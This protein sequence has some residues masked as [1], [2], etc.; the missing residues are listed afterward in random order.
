M[1]LALAQSLEA[2][3]VKKW[4]ERRSPALKRLYVARQAAEQRRAA[5]AAVWFVGI[6]YVVFV[7]AD[8]VLIPDMIGWAFVAR[9]IVGL[10]YAT[11]ISWQIQ[12]GVRPQF[13]EA[14]CA[15]GVVAGCAAWFALIAASKHVE[16]VLYYATFGPVFMMVAN[17]FFNFRFK[18]AV[19]VSGSIAVIFL[20][21]ASLFFKAG[22]EYFF[23][24]GSLYVLSLFLT[25]FLNWKLEAERYRVFLNSLS[26]DLRHQEARE[27]GEELL[28]IS[29]TDALTGLANRRATDGV[30]QMLWKDWTSHEASFA[31]ALIDIDYFK[32]FNDYYGHQR[33][34][35]CLVRVADA[36]EAVALRHR[37]KL[38]RF[39]GE[40][41]I[42]LLSCPTLPDAQIVSE[43]LRQAVQALDI[44][45][46][47]RRDGTAH[48]TVSVGVAFS[49]DVVGTKAERIV[50]D[51]DR[52]LYLAKNG[53]RNCVRAF[54]P[55]AFEND[56]SEDELHELVRT[57]L[58]GE[59]V[60]LVYQPI[61]DLGTGRMMGAE[62][63][64]RLRTEDGRPVSPTTFI[65]IAERTGLIFEFGEWAIRQAC[66]QLLACEAL[67]L[68]SVNV[69]VMQ[70]VQPGF[71][72]AVSDIL[73]RAGV[74]P[75]RLALEITEGAEIEG[76]PAVVQAVADLT[77]LGAKVWLDDFGTGFAGL[78]CLRE[79]RFDAV[80]VDGSFVRNSGT[81]RGARLLRDIISLVQNANSRLVVEGIESREQ[82]ELLAVLGVEL[83]QGYYF[84][85][86]MASEALRALSVEKKSIATTSIAA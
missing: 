5:H 33:G 30:L 60:S 67:P 28:K 4:R 78:S 6:L 32:T 9:V 21:S 41:F 43:E 52:A 80:K 2:E 86:P 50:T 56:G 31:V 46:E 66:Q 73:A 18:I 42:L 20:M 17:L 82:A 3:L 63:L 44:A 74:S 57:A 12:R 24:V 81:P 61:W 11:S 35:T 59:R 10:A 19:A 84:A 71:A 15:L 70:L 69:S 8:F 64:M 29:K 1:D 38:G 75:S 55:N 23:A 49:R 85:R 45:H 37:A 36:M 51:A 58:A 25:L 7:A 72:T 83:V 27:R 40:E 48:V 68:I 76:R 65:P 62:A 34:D 54:D 77:S 79:L 53:G 26:A 14:Q 22:F 39:G 47:A 13:I 16:N